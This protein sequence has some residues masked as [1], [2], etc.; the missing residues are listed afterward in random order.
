[1]LKESGAIVVTD[2]GVEKSGKGYFGVTLAVGSIVIARSRGAARG[3]PRTMC[4]FRAEA[5]GFLAGL[6]LLHSLLQNSTLGSSHTIHTDSASLL[7]RLL[8]A[9]SRVSVGFW[10]KPDSDIVMQITDLVTHIPKLTRHYVKGHQDSKKKKS[11]MTLP[12]IYNCDADA[13]AT[14]MRFEMSKPATNVICFPK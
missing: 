13:S 12:E 9:T 6:C 14:R 10:T 3:D 5:Y 4:S 2:G 1:M 7:A 11:E 8:T